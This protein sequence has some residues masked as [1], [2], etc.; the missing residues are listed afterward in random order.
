M[1]VKNGKFIP[2]T[3][4]GDTEGEWRFSST[5]SATSVLDGDGWFTPH[6]SRFT[7]G[8]DPVPNV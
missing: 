8:S 1:I 3:C 6:P 7:T 5:F 2:I 4:Y